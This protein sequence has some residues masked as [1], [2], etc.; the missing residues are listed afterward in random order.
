M[1]LQLLWGSQL[2]QAQVVRLPLALRTSQETWLQPPSLLR[3][4]RQGCTLLLLLSLSERVRQ[5]SWQV[6]EGASQRQ[7]WQQRAAETWLRVQLH[8]QQL[9]GLLVLQLLL[10]GCQ[11]R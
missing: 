10:K 1:L 11:A 2:L 9:Q 8:C 7:R 4:T 5:G 6:T 3:E